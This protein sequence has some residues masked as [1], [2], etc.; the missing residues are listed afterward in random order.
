MK[1]KLALLSNL[2]YIKTPV[3][4]LWIGSTHCFVSFIKVINDQYAG[5][6]D[7]LLVLHFSLH[8]T[9]FPCAKMLW[10]R[11]WD[12]CAA[13]ISFIP[14]IGMSH[15]AKQRENFQGDICVFLEDNSIPRVAKEMC[16]YLINKQITWRV[17][18]SW[19]YMK[20][21]ENTY[22]SSVCSAAQVENCKH[23]NTEIRIL[24]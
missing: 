6:L 7:F 18:P 20:N 14:W 10:L 12:L 23:Q 1:Y 16:F 15:L 9:H 24:S 3:I 5:I 4:K 13:A 19:L 22:H 21:P 2:K 8:Q 11:E 17:L